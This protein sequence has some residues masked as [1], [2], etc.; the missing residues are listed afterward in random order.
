MNWK[1]LFLVKANDVQLFAAPESFGHEPFDVNNYYLGY[2]VAHWLSRGAPTQLSGVH[3]CPSP[4]EARERTWK[5]TN[6]RNYW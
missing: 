6:S 4:A 2:R 3:R 1:D 5:M